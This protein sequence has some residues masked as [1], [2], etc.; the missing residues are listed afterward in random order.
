[1]TRENLVHTAS[2]VELVRKLASEGDRVFTSARARE[3]APAA[4]LSEGYLRQALH[5]LA[6]SGWVIRL[7]KFDIQ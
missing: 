4:G 6:R 7:R 2:G 3:L 5:H 1:M